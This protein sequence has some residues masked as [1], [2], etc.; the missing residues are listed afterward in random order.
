MP[1]SPFPRTSVHPKHP[2]WEKV[3]LHKSFQHSRSQVTRLLPRCPELG[4]LPAIPLHESPCAPRKGG[5]SHP[6]D[7]LVRV[8]A[9]LACSRPRFDSRHPN[10]NQEQKKRSKRTIYT[11]TSS[12]TPTS[13]YRGLHRLC[14]CLPP[15]TASPAPQD[16][17]RAPLAPN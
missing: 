5:Q 14:T 6:G 17:P 10:L 12:P 13:Y 15:P 16:S 3:L 8:D 4:M 11:L 2:A 7:A 1:P 9:C